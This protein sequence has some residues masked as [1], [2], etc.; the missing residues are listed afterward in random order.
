MGLA[1]G[2]ALGLPL[3]GAVGTALVGAG[4]EVGWAVGCGQVSPLLSAF[5]FLF[6][7]FLFY[8]LK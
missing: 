6:Y 7:L 8:V 2:S 4:A 3:P 5:V 1:L